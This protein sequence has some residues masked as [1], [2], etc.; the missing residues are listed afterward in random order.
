[1]GGVP[2]AGSS[3]V[4]PVDKRFLI[5]LGSAKPRT[6]DRPDRGIWTMSE[7]QALT[8][9]ARQQARCPLD[10]VGCDREGCVAVEGSS[11]S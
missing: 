3:P 1:M 8:R 10:G 11:I 9:S 7:P 6:S 4:A 2:F 5:V